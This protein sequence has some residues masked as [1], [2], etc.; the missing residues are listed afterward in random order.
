[1]SVRVRGVAAWM[2]AAALLLSTW[3]QAEDKRAL[4]TDRE[5]VSYMIGA[6]VGR[7]V[8]SAGPDLDMAAFERAIRNA[9][10]GGQPLLSDEESKIVGTALMQRVAERNGRPVP[11]LPPGMSPPAVAKDKVGLMIGADV[12]RSLASIQDE[13]DMPVF[14]QAV[15]TMM[16]AAKPLLTDAELDEIRDAFAK[17]RASQDARRNAEA[18]AAFLAKNRAEPGVITT[19]S[20]LQYRVLRQGNGRRPRISERVRVH[21]EGTLLQ[22]KVFDSSYQRGQPAVFALNE[23]IAG[24]TE[25][26][27][28]MPVGAKY[29]FWVPGSI[30]YGERGSPPNIGPNETLVFDVELLGMP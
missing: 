10:A 21:Y 29:R 23:V 24:W 30:A 15:R 8:A 13:I 25:G 2:A 22:G 11:G 20:G 18:G 14:L 12:G 5:K 6:D 19:S 3:A 26:L 7:S 17:T 27:M 28:L 9:F 16:S 1:M 4:T